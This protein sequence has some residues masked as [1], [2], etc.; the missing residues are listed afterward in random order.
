MSVD[1]SQSNIKHGSIA[2]GGIINGTLVGAYIWSKDYDFLILYAGIRITAAATTDR[3]HTFKVQMSDSAGAFSSPTDLLTISIATTD[4]AA[5]LLSGRA[6]AGSSLVTHNGAYQCRTA[7]VAT[8][9]DASLD[10]DYYV[11]HSSLHE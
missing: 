6:A 10:Y 5:A 7:H 1:Y 2:H 3:T 8:G 9:T 11:A 4:A